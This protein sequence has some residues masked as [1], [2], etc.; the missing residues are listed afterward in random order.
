VLLA[1]VP[2]AAAQE[3]LPTPAKITTTLPLSAKPLPVP[4]DRALP[5]N[6]PTALQLANARPLDIAVASERINAA[7]AALQRANVL[8]LPT[9]YLGVDYYRHDGQLQDVVGQIF[10]TSKSSLMVGAGP[11][12]VFA[13]T[14]AIFGPLTARQEL[15]ARHAARQ[16]AMNDSLQSV[17]E[18]YFNVQQARGEFA[19]AQD[20]NARVD[21]LLG[22]TQKLVGIIPELEVVR[23]R[24]QLNRSRQSVQS[25]RERWRVASAELNRLLRMDASA[26]VEP[27]EPPHLQ[28]TMVPLEQS[29]DDLIQ[30]GLTNRPELAGQQAVVQATLVRLRQEKVRPLLPSVLLR[31]AST[32]PSGTLAGGLFGGGINDDMSN[33][34]ARGDFDVQV[35]WELQNL[36]F[37]NHALVKQRSAENQQAILELFRTQD[38]IAAEVAQAYAQAQSAAERIIDAEAGVADAVDSAN[39]NLQGLGQTKTA[40]NVLIPLIRPQEVIASLQAL[41]QAYADYYGAV[42]DYDRAQFRLYRAVGRPADLAAGTCNVDA[43]A[44]RLGPVQ[45]E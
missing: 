36:G 41:G 1:I 33:F 17:A 39:K 10:D 28:I 32:N 22:R 29:V 43:I 42:A 3:L 23:A 40:G 27:M 26:L 35:L 9:I 12:A 37:G 38:R 14:D 6:L 45:V 13:V 2:C 34:R 20:V 19:G 44:I 4:G 8:W 16:S 7:A 11:T 21:D 25:A 18:A 24:T 15:H 30:V 5:I 31:G